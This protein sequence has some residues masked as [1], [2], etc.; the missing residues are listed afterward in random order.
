[1][2]VTAQLPTTQALKNTH[3]L[4]CAVPTTL[5]Q[6]SAMISLDIVQLGAGLIQMQCSFH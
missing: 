3:N 5:L 6:D 4:P 2:A 1:M